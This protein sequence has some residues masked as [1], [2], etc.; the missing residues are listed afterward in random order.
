MLLVDSESSIP[1]YEQLKLQLV[2][3]ID[4]GELVVGARLP[5]VR[6]LA[7][8]LGLAP[9]TV[10]KTYRL[11]E[12][13]GYVQTGG[14]AGTVVAGQSQVSA[15]AEVLARKFAHGAR[16]L[17]L[18]SADALRLVRVALEQTEPTKGGR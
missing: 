16:E 18:T 11:L 1:P 13:E 8:D 3:Q 15:A 10:A 4:T 12:V 5:T 2:A 9:N 14:R 7:A 17:G 6:R